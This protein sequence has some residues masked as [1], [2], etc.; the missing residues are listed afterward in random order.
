MRIDEMKISSKDLDL[1]DVTVGDNV[2]L[3]GV[4]W[5]VTNILFDLKIKKKWL[6]FNVKYYHLTATLRPI[7]LI[8]DRVKENKQ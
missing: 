6:I 8:L 2:D 5:L 3:Y 1:K 7:R 4:E